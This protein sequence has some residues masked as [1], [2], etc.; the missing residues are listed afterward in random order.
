MSDP[1]DK[2]ELSKLGTGQPIDL[3]QMYEE[4]EDDHLDRMIE[5]TRAS[6][7]KHGAKE[8]PAT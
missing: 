4:M 3:A 2:P 1:T 7:V 5:A 6:K 8:D